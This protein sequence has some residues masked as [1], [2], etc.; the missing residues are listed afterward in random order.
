VD[1]DEFP[2]KPLPLK[3][4]LHRLRERKDNVRI[5][6]CSPDFANLTPQQFIKAATD[7]GCDAVIE[8]PFEPTKLLELLEKLFEVAAQQKAEA[9]AKA[10]AAREAAEQAEEEERRAKRAAREA[11]ENEEDVA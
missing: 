3:E 11:K 4:T 9:K 10:D 7:L 8:K 1:D 5:I 6:A 2:G